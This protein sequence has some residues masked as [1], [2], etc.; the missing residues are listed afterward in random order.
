MNGIAVVALPKKRKKKKLLRRHPIDRRDATNCTDEHFC[1]QWEEYNM[2]FILANRRSLFIN[3]NSF[4]LCGCCTQPEIICDCNRASPVLGQVFFVVFIYQWNDFPLFF[5]GRRSIH[6]LTHTHTR[7]GDM[8]LSFIFFL[9]CCLCRL[10][11]TSMA[12]ITPTQSR[13]HY[14]HAIAAPFIQ[15]GPPKNI[16]NPKKESTSNCIFYTQHFYSIISSKKNY[17]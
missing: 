15:F 12:K 17:F 14:S 3:N 7:T 16:E 8:L 6:T 2:F 10:P 5:A 1:S 11:W 9:F 13:S 4:K